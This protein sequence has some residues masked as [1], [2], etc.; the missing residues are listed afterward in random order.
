MRM[1]PPELPAV[2]DEIRTLRGFMVV[3]VTAANAPLPP[4]RVDAAI[5]VPPGPTKMREAAEIINEFAGRGRKRAL[6]GR[7]L[8][9]HCRSD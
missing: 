9:L 2:I 5:V 1:P 7:R 3:V 8:I 4:L 6:R